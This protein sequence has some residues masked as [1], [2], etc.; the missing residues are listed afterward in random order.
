M[1]IRMLVRR[2]LDL[3]NEGDRR[4]TKLVDVNCTKLDEQ[5]CTTTFSLIKQADFA[6]QPPLVALQQMRRGSRAKSSVISSSRQHHENYFWSTII[7][8]HHSCAISSCSNL[9]SHHGI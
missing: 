8:S 2:G 5:E 9:K 7:I 6:K 4:D 3:R 1:F